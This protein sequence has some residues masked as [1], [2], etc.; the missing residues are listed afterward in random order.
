MLCLV[1]GGEGAGIGQCILIMQLLRF[2]VYDCISLQMFVHVWVRSIS[3]KMLLISVPEVIAHSLHWLFCHWRH[4]CRHS[5]SNVNE[6]LFSVKLVVQ[7]F[8]WSSYLQNAVVFLANIIDLKTQKCTFQK[9]FQKVQWQQS[10][11]WCTYKT[12]CCGEQ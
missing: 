7:W 9:V 3:V 5:C 2:C 8:K 4:A 6:L 11:T 10:A 1:M 12:C